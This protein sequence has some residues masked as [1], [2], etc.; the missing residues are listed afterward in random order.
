VALAF[1]LFGIVAFVATVALGL[2][3]LRKHNRMFP[4]GFDRTGW[5]PPPGRAGRFETMWAWLSGG[6]GG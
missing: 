4:K 2:W 5:E 6:R 1:A 3:A